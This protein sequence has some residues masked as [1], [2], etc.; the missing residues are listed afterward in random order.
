LLRET[1]GLY[2]LKVRH[3][4][5][6]PTAAGLKYDRHAVD[7]TYTIFAAGAVPEFYRRCYVTVVNTSTDDATLVGYIVTGLEAYLNA[8]NV[9]K[10]VNWES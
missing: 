3:S 5:D 2:R 9:T 7:F 10:V 8:A 4:T 1:T 6:K